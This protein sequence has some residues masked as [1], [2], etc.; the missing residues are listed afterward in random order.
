MEL[1]FRR[2]TVRRRV[3]TPTYIHEHVR[4]CRR[5]SRGWGTYRSKAWVSCLPC[6]ATRRY[7]AA[8]IRLHETTCSLCDNAYSVVG[9]EVA[10]PRCGWKWGRVGKGGAR[11]INAW[12]TPSRKISHIR[13]FSPGIHPPHVL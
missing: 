5:E 3:M 9:I 8:S 11:G 4:T 13:D 12:Y 7:D 1:D 2:T 10:T 6:T